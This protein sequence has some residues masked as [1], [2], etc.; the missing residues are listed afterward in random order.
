MRILIPLL[1]FGKAGGYRVLS[2]LANKWI[3][4][5]HQVDFIVPIASIEPYFPTDARIYWFNSSGKSCTA[6]DLIPVNEYK[7]WNRWQ[8]LYKGMEQLTS[9]YDVV[10]ANHSLTAYP[11]YFTKIKAKKFYYIQAYEPEYGILDGRLSHKILSLLAWNSYNLKLSKIV[12]SDVYRNYRNITADKVVFPGL[13]LSVFYPKSINESKDKKVYK[14]GCVGRIE[15]YKG[16]KYV[17]DG[18][19]LLSKQRNDIE[20]H[21]A[22]GDKNI[23]NKTD[24]VFVTTPAN[25]LELSDFYRSMNIIVAPGTVQMGGVH[26]PIIESMACGTSIIATGYYPADNTNAWMVPI[27][28]SVAIADRIETIINSPDLRNIKIEKALSE[29]QQFDWNIVATKMSNYFKQ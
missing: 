5:G 4:F 29:V 6:S 28:D 25:D 21:I 13:D 22:F 20:L 7:F 8:A 1:E 2:K 16:T 14:I 24:K 19:K 9:T 10:L 3:E 27:K 18:F 11:V 26:Y 23:E 12:N 15:P 17:L